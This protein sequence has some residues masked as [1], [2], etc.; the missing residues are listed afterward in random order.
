[1]TKTPS[2]LDHAAR[3][4][5]ERPWT[6]GAVLE[7]YSR[8]EGVTRAETASFLGCDV[9]SLAWL[10]LCRKPA[11]DRFLEDVSRIAERFQIDGFKLAQLIRRVDAIVVL[12]RTTT[13]EEETLLLAARDRD[14]ETE[15]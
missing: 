11:P 13:A 6:L 14:E 9:D 3:H 8:V 7:E 2:W 10:S 1:M 5:S 4:S 15:E 12:R